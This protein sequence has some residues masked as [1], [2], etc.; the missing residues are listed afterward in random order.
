MKKSGQW[1]A[2]EDTMWP[3][4]CSQDEFSLGEIREGD[5]LTGL[6]IEMDNLEI[7]FSLSSSFNYHWTWWIIITF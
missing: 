6:C 4:K 5:K 2:E 3:Y 1:K 7:S